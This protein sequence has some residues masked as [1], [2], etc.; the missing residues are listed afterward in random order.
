MTPDL[1]NDGKVNHGFPGASLRD[2][3]RDQP[4]S[5]YLHGSS[6]EA[7]GVGSPADTAGLKVGDIILQINNTTVRSALEAIRTIAGFRDGE[8]SDFYVERNG[9]I[10]GATPVTVGQR[11][12]D[13]KQLAAATGNRNRTASSPGPAARS[14]SADSMDNTGLSL[15]GLSEPFR[16]TIGMQR[17]QVEVYAEAVTP[18]RNAAHKDIKSGMVILEVKSQPVI[19]INLFWDIVDKATQSGQ[20]FI[21]VMVQTINDSE[22]LT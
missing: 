7:I 19:N 2:T 22:T 5:T 8:I 1:I 11:P 15:V 6:I 16:D 3:I 10:L 4:G 20:R 21:P 9:S 14:P 18:G 17:D 12:V 13:E